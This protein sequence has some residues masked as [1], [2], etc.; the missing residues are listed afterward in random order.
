MTDQD[1]RWCCSGN[2][3]EC[4]LCDTAS[5]PYPWICP[6]HSD[7]P[8]NRE[9]ATK[10]PP[11]VLTYPA[12]S[13]DFTVSASQVEAS[14]LSLPFNGRPLVTIDLADGTMTFGPDYTPNEAA[15]LFWQAVQD[16]TP[17]P[18]VREFGPQL[19]A[20]INEHLKAGQEAE[21]A[22]ARVEQVCHDLPYEYARLI[23]AAL[24]NK[25]PTT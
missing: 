5:L 18:A 22:I 8:E 14:T 12:E 24:E 9:K 2:A 23:L 4:C 15:R 10:N 25:E 7:T 6:G 11:N 16:A 1:E 20:R 13:S 19:H 17:P 3:E 21:Q